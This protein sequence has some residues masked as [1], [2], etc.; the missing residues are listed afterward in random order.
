[1]YKYDYLLTFDS[2]LSPIRKTALDM[3][4]LTKKLQ[5]VLTIVFFALSVISNVIITVVI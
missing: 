4:I 3:T 2:I 1:M 5:T